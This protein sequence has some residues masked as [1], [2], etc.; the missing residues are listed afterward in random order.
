MV[1]FGDDLTLVGL[2]G[3]VVVD[4]A[5]RLKR[6]LTG[7][8][9]WVAGYTNDVFGYVP[10]VRVLKEGGY[11]GGGA[12]RFTRL[13][14]PFAP[15]V[16]ERIVGKVHELVKQVQLEKP[17]NERREP[18]A[19]SAYADHHDLSYYL[20]STGR[21]TPIRTREDWAERRRHIVKSLKLVMGPLPDPMP[22]SP[23]DLQVHEQLP[24]G[25]IVR[26][27]ISYQSEPGKRVPAYLFL[28]PL[29]PGAKAA[30]IL[31]LHQTTKLGKGEPAGMGGN[32]NLHY[33]LHLAERGFVT[34]APDYPSFGEHKWDFEAK[35]AATTAA[36]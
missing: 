18:P 21:K 15:S 3:E 1:Q 14:G 23:L 27:K 12:M 28:P 25:A 19:L 11:E 17:R 33:A 30:A 8:T 31:C 35:P 26:R 10:S 34:L 16:E 32:P 29:K 9:V 5:L 22:R 36:A 4:Y 7:T 2:A 6:E 13:P 20:D 24:G